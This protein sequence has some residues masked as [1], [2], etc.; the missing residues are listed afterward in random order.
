[1]MNQE[2][3][4]KLLIQVAHLAQKAGALSLPEA[5]AVNVAIQ[6]LSV[7]KEPQNEELKKEVTKGA[8]SKKS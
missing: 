2:Q 4:I 1:M 7:K 6:T 3:A 8:V 5:S